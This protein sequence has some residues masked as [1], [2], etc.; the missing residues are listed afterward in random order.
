MTEHVPAPG[1]EGPGIAWWQRV[2]VSAVAALA[3]LANI[4]CWLMIGRVGENVA[5]GP[6]GIAV[7]LLLTALTLGLAATAVLAVWRARAARATELLAWFMCLLSWTIIARLLK[8]GPIEERLLDLWLEMRGATHQDSM[9][10]VLAAIRAAGPWL[11]GLDLFAHAAAMLAPALFLLF[12]ERFP[13]PLDATFR[14]RAALRE[15]APPLTAY[16]PRREPATL[17]VLAVY[18]LACAGMGLLFARSVAIDLRP[19][20]Q[21]LTVITS[22]AAVLAVA[23]WVAR[24]FEGGARRFAIERALTAQPADRAVLPASSVVLLLVLSAA[25]HVARDGW[26]MAASAAEDGTL[27]LT[28]AGLFALPLLLRIRLVRVR[29]P[30]VFWAGLTV[31]AFGSA[32]GLLSWFTYTTGLLDRGS[33]AMAWW[34][35]VCSFAALG[36]LLVAYVH[37]DAADRARIR[38]VLLG[39]FLSCTAMVGLIVYAMGCGLEAWQCTNSARVLL[40]GVN[41]PPTLLVCCMSIAVFYRGDIDSALA[42]RRSVTYVMVGLVLMVVFSGVE[43]LLDHAL[44]EVAVPDVS[45]WIAGSI[46]VLVINPTKHA[47][48][49]AVYRVGEVLGKLAA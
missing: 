42:L 30:L 19:L 1:R 28:D 46:S 45:K 20:L 6:E 39:I 16:V 40:W 41:A 49:K 36:N 34:T 29:S 3:V 17:E 47:C 11:V 27:Y 31:L 2:G 43:I 38:W 9:E 18:S 25:L 21:A 35:L 33:A 37:A 8:T 10:P 14:A 15:L 7:S 26:H 48:E 44:A 12:S 5:F 4:V 22:G 13:R 32:P 24:R 23:V